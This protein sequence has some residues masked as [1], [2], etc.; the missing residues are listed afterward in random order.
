MVGLDAVVLAD[1]DLQAGGCRSA[2]Q[3]VATSVTKKGDA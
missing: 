1:E 3:V 2:Q